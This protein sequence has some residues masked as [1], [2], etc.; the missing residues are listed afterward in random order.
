MPVQKICES[1]FSLKTGYQNTLI[2]TRRYKSDSISP[3]LTFETIHP[4]NPDANFIFSF[5]GPDSHFTKTLNYGEALRDVYSHGLH[6]HDF[7]EL[8]YVIRGKFFQQIENQR[9][10]YPEGSLC[11]LNRNIRHQEEFSTDYRCV[12]LMLPTNL[13]LGMLQEFDQFFFDMEKKTRNR[14]SEQFFRAN[15]EN[16]YSMQKEYI[17]FIPRGS[18][19]Q[20]Q[21]TRQNM[22]MLFEDLTQQFLCP[23]PGSS[24]LIRFFIFKIFQELADRKKYQTI[25]LNIGTNA[26]AELF[27]SVT[28]FFNKCNRPVTRAHIEAELS[29]SAD[30]INRIIRKYTGMSFHQYNMTF[31]IKKAAEL[32][33]NTSLSISE[34]CSHLHMSN[35]TQFYRLF[36]NVYGMTP[37]AY[38]ASL[39]KD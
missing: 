14:L 25:P 11:L 21:E 13:I 22:Y 8:L 15:L 5:L 3:D 12:F 19:S 1:P 2:H 31:V 26:E 16:P 6:R 32:L 29:Y 38:R 17:D 35:Q 39:K 7:F 27:A 10:L 34:I 28:S 23:Q 30:Y 20:L 37:K 36:E 18:G 9:H 4:D 33:T 24:Y